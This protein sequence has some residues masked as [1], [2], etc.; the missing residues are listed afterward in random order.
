MREIHEDEMADYREQMA[1]EK[2]ER[3]QVRKQRWVDPR[4]P[5]YVAPEEEE[6]EE[7]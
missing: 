3:E 1:Q 4:D 5:N 2:Y 7:V 6:N